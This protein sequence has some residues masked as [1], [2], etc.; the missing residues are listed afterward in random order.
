MDE[1]HEYAPRPGEITKVAVFSHSGKKVSTY[2]TLIEA[3][4]AVYR[5]DADLK[6]AIETAVLMTTAGGDDE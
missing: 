2:E 4:T 3:L 6:R 5:L 1:H